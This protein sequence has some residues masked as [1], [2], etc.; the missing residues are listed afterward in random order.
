ML[1]RFDSERKGVIPVEE[2]KFVMKN[3]PV[4]VS[5]EEIDAMIEAVDEDGNGTVDIEEFKMMIGFGFC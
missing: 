1:H 4:K 2:I 3:L 5:E